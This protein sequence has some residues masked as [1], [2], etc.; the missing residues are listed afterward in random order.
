MDQGPVMAFVEYATVEVECPEHGVVVAAVPW[1]EHASASRASSSSRSPGSHAGPQDRHGRAHAHRLGERR[2]HMQARL[3][4]GST[5]RPGTAST[6]WSRIGIDETSYK[7]GHKYMTV[8]LDHDANRVVWCAKGH[9]KAVLKP[10]FE[11]LSEDQRAS[12]RVVTADGARWI[13]ELAESTTA[14]TP[15]VMDPFHVVSWMTDVVDELRKQAWRSPGRRETRRAR[16]RR[17]QG[18]QGQQ[19]RAAQEPRGPHRGPGRVAREGWPGGQALYRAYLLKER[20][21]DVFKTGSGAEARLR[22]GRGSPAP[23][24]PGSTGQ[25]SPRRCGAKG[26]HRQ[27]RG[28]GISTPGSRPSTTRSSSR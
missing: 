22:L 16:G 15:R 19:V 26:R 2:R 27:G 7:K 12:I 9:G 13:A 20:L 11:Q 4:R 25:G 24:T 23:A 17:G 28:L 5:P 10:F 6:A 3:R 8:V 21:R 14:P 18:S 1:A